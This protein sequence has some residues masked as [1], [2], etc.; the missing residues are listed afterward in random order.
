MRQHAGKKNYKANQ[1][2]QIKKKKRMNMDD[3]VCFVCGENGHFAKKCKNRKGKK[4]Q[5]EQKCANM[6][7]CDPSRFGHGNLQYIFYVCQSND[8][9]I[10]TRSNIHVCIDISMFS[11]YKVRRGSTIMMGNNSHAIVLGVGMIDL[12]FISGKIVRLK[13]VQHASSINKNLFSGSII[14]RDGSK[15]VFE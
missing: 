5:P 14:C 12:K 8:W 1:T 13:N 9:W 10:D 7:I 6:T 15:L 11:S 3:V 2:T 4:N